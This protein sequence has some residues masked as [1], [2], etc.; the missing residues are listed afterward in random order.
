MHTVVLMKNFKIIGMILVGICVLYTFFCRIST[1][2]YEL[3]IH[4][5]DDDYSTNLMKKDF[6]E[7][8]ICRWMEDVFVPYDGCVFVVYHTSSLFD[9]H[10]QAGLIL[11]LI[12]DR[13]Q[14]TLEINSI[15]SKSIEFQGN[16][17]YITKQYDPYTRIYTLE[18]EY[19]GKE[20]KREILYSKNSNI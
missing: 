9:N 13:P 19:I 12:N 16:Q 18:G 4:D 15:Y 11:V 1:P 8:G 6:S 14:Y 3:I 2:E 17:M 20:S 7:S 10:F 5:T